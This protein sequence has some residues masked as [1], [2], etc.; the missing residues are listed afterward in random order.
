MA[1]AAAKA[2]ARLHS[3]A[4]GGSAEAA[5]AA[6]ATAKATT[7]KAKAEEE[8]EDGKAT[9]V[10]TAHGPMLWR[11]TLA[12]HAHAAHADVSLAHFEKVCPSY[13]RLPF[14]SCYLL[15]LHA[16]F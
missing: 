11:L 4:A 15:C 13:S 3:D 9:V 8:A 5:A 6:T 7:A 1:E 14:F 2:E 16:Y 12:G 10:V